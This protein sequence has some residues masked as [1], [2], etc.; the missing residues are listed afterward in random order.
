M[1]KRIRQPAVINYLGPEDRWKALGIAVVKQAV[2]D[3]HEARTSLSKPATT[4]KDMAEQ[5]RSAEH[6][7]SSSVCELY[8]GC[9]GK[10]ILR[11]LKDGSLI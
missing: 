4:T 7:L 10:T 6:F 11:K 5:K 3:W 1:R 2:V 8:S 9:D